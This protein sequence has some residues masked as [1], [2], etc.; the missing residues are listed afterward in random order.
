L[1]VVTAQEDQRGKVHDDE[2][3]DRVR[4]LNRLL[5]TQDEDFLVLASDWQQ[6]NR[7][8][9]GVAF[10]IRQHLVGRYVNDLEL[11][12]KATDLREWENAIIF[13]PF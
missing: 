10:G 2:L 3:L 5:F 6:T 11:I 1:D 13:P 8:V 9:G 4:E 12:A 7:P